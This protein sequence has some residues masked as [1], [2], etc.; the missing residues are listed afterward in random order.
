[1]NPE[2]TK[3]ALPLS[4]DFVTRSPFFCDTMLLLVAIQKGEFENADKNDH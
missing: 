3:P 4:P 1:M 2:S